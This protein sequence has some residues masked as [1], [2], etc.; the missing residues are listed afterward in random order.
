MI[1]PRYL[2][3][4]LLYERVLCMTLHVTGYYFMQLQSASPAADRTQ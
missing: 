3:A 1:Q 4:V 2:N